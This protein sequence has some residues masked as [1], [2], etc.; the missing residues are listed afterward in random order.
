MPDS[1]K[2]PPELWE[3]LRLFYN[4]FFDL[5]GCRQLG[6]AVG[7]IDWI[8]IDRYCE[9]YQIEGEQY[10]A[11]H[12]HIGRMDHAYLERDRDQA[13]KR[14]DQTQRAAESKAKRPASTPRARRRR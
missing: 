9:R 2:D 7:P 12:Y 1:L 13:K 8:A 3:G 10:D 11:M 14:R 6:D 4:A 5:H